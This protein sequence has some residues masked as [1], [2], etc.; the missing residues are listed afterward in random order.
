MAPG[1]A[2][3][4]AKVEPQ[5]RLGKIDTEAEQA[6]AARFAI[7]SIPSLVLVEKG[8]TIARTAGARPENALLQWIDEAMA[9]RRR[10]FPGHSIEG[11][12]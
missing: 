8:K 11:Q 6:L 2:A 5:L 10:H 3:T 4:A 12:A 7:Q 1:F 9:S